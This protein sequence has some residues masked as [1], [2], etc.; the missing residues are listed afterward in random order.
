MAAL[1]ILLPRHVNVLAALT[2][3]IPAW[4]LSLAPNISLP[5]WRFRRV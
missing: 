2:I 4:F 1:P 3:G 5:S